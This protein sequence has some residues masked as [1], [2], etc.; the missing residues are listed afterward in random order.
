MQKKIITFLILISLFLGTTLLAQ[1]DQAQLEEIKRQIQDARVMLQDKIQE[2][3]DEIKDTINQNRVM[4]QSELS[5]ALEGFENATIAEKE[6]IRNRLE[7]KREELQDQAQELRANLREHAQEMR[8][9]F[10]EKVTSLRDRVRI[11]AA[12]GKGLRMLNRLRS[13]IARFDHILSRMDSRLQ[14]LEDSGTDTSSVTPLIEEAKNMLANSEATMEELKAKYEELLNGENVGGS[15]EEAKEIATTIKEEVESL[16]SKL[17]EI[18][19][20]MK[21]LR[22]DSSAT[23]TEQ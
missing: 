21:A 19:S 15:G 13:A 2:E 10:R 9:N 12:H 1:V 14:K 6:Q 23:S 22:P 17:R 5:T 7:L 11:A 4:I 20:A 16:H 18:A 3:R 8:D